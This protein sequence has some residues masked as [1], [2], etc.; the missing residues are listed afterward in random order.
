[1]V[2]D[3]TAGVEIGGVVGGTAV[4]CGVAGSEVSQVAPCCGGIGA[5]AV[6]VVVG[7]AVSFTG[8]WFSPPSKFSSAAR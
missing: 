4:G 7:T 5:S 3:D 1:M 8:G 2:V 6:V